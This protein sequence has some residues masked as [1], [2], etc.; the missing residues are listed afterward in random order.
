MRVADYHTYFVGCEEWGWSVW[1]HNAYKVVRVEGTQA[2]TIVDETGQ[3]IAAVKGK[4][5][6]NPTNAK[7]FAEGEGIVGLNVDKRATWTPPKS[8]APTPDIDGVANLPR[9]NIDPLDFTPTHPASRHSAAE[10][11]AL[12]RSISEKG[13]LDNP[14][15]PVAYTVHNGHKYIVNGHHRIRAARE[16]G[17]NEIPAVEVSLPFKGFRNTDDLIF[18][19]NY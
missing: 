13:F 6:G 2:W 14:T 10:F 5:F 18:D 9:N 7:K 17:L 16:L 1:A 12:K 4:S 11:A 8:D 15:E 19:H 3:P